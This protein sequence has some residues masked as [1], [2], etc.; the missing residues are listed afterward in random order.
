VSDHEGGGKCPIMGLFPNII[1][2]CCGKLLTSGG[3]LMSY[4][5]ETLVM[6]ISEKQEA[7]K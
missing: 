5:T 3:I 2:F 7:V 4:F 1:H 6:K